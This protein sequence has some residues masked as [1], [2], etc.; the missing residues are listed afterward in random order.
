MQGIQ[1][2]MGPSGEL[3]YPLCK[4]ELRYPS[5]TSE[6]LTWSWHSHEL[7][8]FQC[9]DKVSGKVKH[10][11]FACGSVLVPLGIRSFH[12]HNDINTYIDFSPHLLCTVYAGISECLR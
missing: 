12:S 10:N 11:K 2:G 5:C 1:V 7:G 6:K 9:Y 8:E 4:F 3:R